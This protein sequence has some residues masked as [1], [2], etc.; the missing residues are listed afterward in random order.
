MLRIFFSK[1]SFCYENELEYKLYN[2][3]V[4]RNEIYLEPQEREMKKVQSANIVLQKNFRSN[5]RSYRIVSNLTCRI[6]AL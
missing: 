5:D 2:Y 3:A 6:K 4:N 1:I